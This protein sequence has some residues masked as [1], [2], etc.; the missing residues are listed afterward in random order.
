MR[1]GN[2]AKRLLAQT[3][4]YN[5]VTITRRVFALEVGQ[6]AF[7]TVNHHD[8]T[9]TGMMVLG[10]CFE[11]AVEFVDTSGQ[12]RDL[13][14]RRSGVILA[15]CVIGYDSGLACFFEGHGDLPFTCD[16][17]SLHPAHREQRLKEPV[18]TDQLRSIAELPQAFKHLRDYFEVTA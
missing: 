4:L 9:A 15:T 2:I 1:A 13:D 17:Q 6:Q 5:Q 14:F 3:E 7:T 16:I 10:V 12:Q 8:Q 11:V 18:K